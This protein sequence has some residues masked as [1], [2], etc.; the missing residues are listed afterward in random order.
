M[1]WVMVWPATRFEP[2][3]R[4]AL[5]SSVRRAANEPCKSFPDTCFPTWAHDGELAATSGQGANCS[6]PSDLQVRAPASILNHRLQQ[7]L[8]C[9]FRAHEIARPRERRRLRNCTERALIR[10]RGAYRTNLICDCRI[11]LRPDQTP[12]SSRLAGERFQVVAGAN[13]R[14][15]YFEG[16]RRGSHSKCAIALDVCRLSPFCQDS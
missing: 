12:T 5:R 15:G 6:L 7:P 11:D 13:G 4:R 9:P 1:P 8:S 2:G 10:L 14:I 16:P 3:R